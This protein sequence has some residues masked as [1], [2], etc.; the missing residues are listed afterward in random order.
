[1][2]AQSAF[3]RSLGVEI[4]ESGH[5]RWPEAVKARAVAETLEPGATVNAV[6]ARYGVKPNQLSAWRCLAKQGRLVL[7]AAE[8]A[9]EPVTFAP[10][11]LCEPEPP[12]APEPSPHSADK[13]RL[14]FG[15]VTIELTADTPA[16]RI[17]EILHA[18]GAPS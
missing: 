18:L 8:M 4:F 11:V 15:D 12:Q 1:M 3:L 5:R 10:L 6:A 14:I 13:L 2:D 16:A 17:A 9:D 7:P